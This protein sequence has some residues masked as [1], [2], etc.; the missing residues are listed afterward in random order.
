MTPRTGIRTGDALETIGELPSGSIRTIVTSPP[1]YGLRDYGNPGQI[2]LEKSPE[3]YIER[4]VLVFR[5]AR[6]VLS[7]DGTVWLNLGDSYQGKSGRLGPKQLLGIPWRVA[8]ALQADGWFLRQDIIW[9]KPN[10][11]PESVTDRCTKSHEYI[12]MLTKSAKYYFD[13][14]AIKE[15]S[16]DKESHKG[17]NKRT[18]VT[19]EKESMAGK[20]LTTRSGFKNIEDG[21]T[22]PFRNKRDV[23]TIT[24]KPFKGAHFAVMPPDLVEPC[25][26]AG[27]EPGDTVLD[28]FCGSGTVGVVAKRLSRSF[29]GIDLNPEYVAMAEQRIKDEAVQD[30]LV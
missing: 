18:A 29:I 4:L 6:R 19:P 7:N 27:S 1:Y 25:I 9:A 20:Y 13:H 10:P 23:W 11:M 22:Y 14:E 15:P 12:F 5:A 2:G 21:K 8:L 17:R 3:E 16:V 30:T 28:P 24:T 26:L